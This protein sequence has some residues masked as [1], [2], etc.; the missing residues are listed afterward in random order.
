MFRSVDC[1]TASMVRYGAVQPLWIFTTAPLTCTPPPVR[2]SPFRSPSAVG[3]LS[4]FRPLF[5]P[6]A[7]F[8]PT[9]SVGD[10]KAGR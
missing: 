1:V 8:V 4:R 5:V 10:A 7:S 9:T 6:L 2:R 3:C